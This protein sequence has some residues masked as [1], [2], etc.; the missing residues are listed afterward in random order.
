MIIEKNV[1]RSGIDT[2]MCVPGRYNNTISY[3]ATAFKC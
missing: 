1:L 2:F 3:D